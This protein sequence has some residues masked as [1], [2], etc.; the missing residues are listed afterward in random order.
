MSSTINRPPNG[1]VRLDILYNIF[2]NEPITDNGNEYRIKKNG[3]VVIS[4]ETGLW[5]D[6]VEGKG[7]NFHT[8][9]NAHNIECNP[10]IPKQNT[11]RIIDKKKE[12]AK[13]ALKLYNESKPIWGTPAEYY[14]K[15]RMLNP[16]FYPSDFRYLETK[17]EKMLVAPI[18]DWNR[19]IKGI[20]R[21][22]L[23]ENGEKIDKRSLG[24]VSG[25]GVWLTEPKILNKDLCIVEGLEDGL[26]VIQENFG[27]SVVAT[28]GATHLQNFFV[29]PQIETVTI[30][31]D[32]DTA[33]N[34]ACDE[35]ALK[36]IDEFTVKQL[37][38]EFPYKDFNEQLQ[39]KKGLLIGVLYDH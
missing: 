19:A 30:L 38:P 35:F 36:H 12:K 8:L 34:K 13:Y 3:S 24:Y 4:K 16:V 5:Y 17:R 14:L 26:S 11:D 29:P 32:N 37:S 31:K 20:H 10:I 28:T 2:P 23:N 27:I 22:F 39:S 18:R 6:F 25:N 1:E 21:I 15:S 33:S 9:C 7:G